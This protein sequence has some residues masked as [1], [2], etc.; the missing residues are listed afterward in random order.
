VKGLEGRGWGGGEQG[1]PYTGNQ[2]WL[3]HAHE[4]LG[5]FYANTWRWALKFKGSSQLAKKISV[6]GSTERTP[7]RR[8]GGGVELQHFRT[9]WEGASV[10]RQDS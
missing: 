3:H 9:N 2:L 1:T 4:V 10:R 6:E 5:P 8:G 7:E